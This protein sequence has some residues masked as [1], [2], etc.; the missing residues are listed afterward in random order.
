M[1]I[2][3]CDAR[4][5]SGRSRVTVRPR[6]HVPK[7]PILKPM[8][9]WDM[10]VA[11]DSAKHME[12][13]E[14]FELKGRAEVHG[15]FRAVLD[16]QMDELREVRDQEAANKQQEIDDMQAQ[17]QENARIKHAEEEREE[18]K[19]GKMKKANNEMTLKLEQRRQKEVERKQKE[20]EDV[21]NWVKGEQERQEQ[22]RKDHAEDYARKCAKAKKEMTEMHAASEARKAAQK[23]AEKKEV[24]ASQ[25]AMDAAEGAGRKAVMDRMDKLDRMS[26]TFGA[27]VA[28]RDAKEKADLESRIK[29]AQE[30][31]ERASKEDGERRK[32]SHDAKVKDMKEVRAKQVKEKGLQDIA[33]VESGKKQALIFAEQL[34]EGAAKDDAKKERGRKAR[35]EQDLYLMKQMRAQLACHPLQFGMTDDTKTQDIA[36]NREIFEQMAHEGFEEELTS[37]FLQFKMDKGRSGKLDPLPSVPCSNAVIHPLEQFAPDV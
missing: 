31:G 32:S 17:I 16:A 3:D 36:M 15:R 12:E 27:A 30:E 14:A 23:A 8:D 4:S 37:S 13:E 1:A 9:H 6:Y 18:E 21:S 22:E 28:A 25:K 20:Q 2:T 35:E 7:K 24:V 11:Y 33:D 29:R 19:I 5:D 26:K 34:A 10:I